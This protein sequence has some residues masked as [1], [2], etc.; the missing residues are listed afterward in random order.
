MRLRVRD[1]AVLLEATGRSSFA[2]P[3]LRCDFTGR[4]LAGFLLGDDRERD[5]RP[6][7]GSA[8]LAPVTSG[9]PRLPVRMTF[10]TRW[11]G[12]ATMYLVDVGSGS[13]T[14]VARGD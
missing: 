9:G 8:W 6:V 12:E 4:M 10:E 13:D 1:S 14:K 5:R 11:F 7:R 2:G 3:A